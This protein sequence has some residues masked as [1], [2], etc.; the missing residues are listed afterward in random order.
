MLVERISYRLSI[1][2]S[3]LSTETLLSLGDGVGLTRKLAYLQVLHKNISVESI[4]LWTSC[5]ERRMKVCHMDVL[6]D[7]VS[8]V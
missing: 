3:I 6:E 2:V 7:I 1:Q 8:T 5:L 4:P